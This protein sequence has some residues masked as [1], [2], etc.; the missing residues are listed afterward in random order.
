MLKESN[1]GLIFN[2]QKFS[3]H[4]GPGIRTI[5]FFKGCPLRCLWCA[6]PEGIE[7]YAQVAFKENKCLGIEKCGLCIEACPQKAI[8]C[9]QNN[10]PLIQRDNCNNCCLCANVCPA[11]SLEIFGKI[12]TTDEIIKVV[13]DDSNFFSRSGGGLT[14]SGGEPLLQAGFTLSLLKSA[15]KEG[16]MTAIET[17]LFAPWN[18]IEQIF[19]Y[20]DFIHIDLKNMDD[21]KHQIFTGVSNELILSN[22]IKVVKVF[23]DKPI[24]VRTP[25]VEGFNCTVEDIQA[26]ANFISKAA[27]LGNAKNIQYEL[28]PYHSFGESKYESLGLDYPMKHLRNMDKKII[29]NLKA[30]IN[31]DINLI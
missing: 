19:P 23:K 5:V 29:E 10:Y 16:L 18:V 1:Q 7:K 24:I 17:T 11:H 31:T 25:V 9:S 3:V 6:N 13:E 22:F 30:N 15:K 14:L 28:L 20:I 4:D 8:V 12:M 26:I 2:I 27:C 21:N